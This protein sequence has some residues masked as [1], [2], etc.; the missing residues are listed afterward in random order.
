MSMH[1]ESLRA[2]RPVTHAL[3]H[4]GIRYHV[5]GS[6]ASSAYGFARSTIDVDLIANIAPGQAHPLA[7]QLGED[8]YA[9]PDSIRDAIYHHTSFNVIYLPLMYKIDVFPLKHRAYDVQAFER[10]QVHRVVDDEP[11]SC[12][13]LASPEDVVLNKLEWYRLGNEVADRQWLDL[14]NVI[15]VQGEALDHG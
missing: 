7:A 5:G 4:L 12:F 11:D 10:A 9:A 14:V 15:K 8:F 6:L 1:D 3:D 13:P 2:M